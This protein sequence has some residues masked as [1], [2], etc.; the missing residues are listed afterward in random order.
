MRFGSC[1]NW[2]FRMEEQKQNFSSQPRSQSQE[3]SAQRPAIRTMKSDVE[4]LFKN[5]KPSLLQIIGQGTLEE[6]PPKGRHLSSRLL[7]AG[8]TILIGALVLGLGFY[9]YAPSGGAPAPQKLIPP[10]PFFATEAARTITVDIKNRASFLRLMEDSSFEFERAGTVKRVL[11]KVQDGPT[12]RFATVADMLRFWQVNSPQNFLTELGAPLM[13]FFYFGTGGS[14][15]GFLVPTKDSD[16]TLASLLS[17][18]SNILADFR[19]LLF[20][21]KP[22]RAVA[23]FEDRTYRNID[24]RYMKLS[25]KQDLG[26]GYAVFPAKNLLLVATNKE[27]METIISRLFDAR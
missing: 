2:F 27:T 14:R 13:T 1:F 6:L 7:Y 16:R 15:F 17:W 3:T 19:P 26:I 25:E 8:G 12:E 9:F 11:I 10:A 20:D 22:E 18:E 4:R 5:T 23:P 24:W 21:A